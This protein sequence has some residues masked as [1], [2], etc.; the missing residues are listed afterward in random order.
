MLKVESGAT[1]TIIDGSTAQTGTIRGGWTQNGGNINNAGTLN[2]HGG[3]ITGGGDVNAKGGGIWNQGTLNI[4]GNVRVNGN[5]GSDIFLPFDK[6]VNVTGAI[7]SGVNSIGI[8][9]EQTGVF[10]AGYGGA[11]AIGGGTNFLGAEVNITGGIVVAFSS[12]ED[13]AI[14]NGGYCKTLDNGK[15]TIPA[16]YQ[17]KAG[18]NAENATFIA[19][20]GRVAACQA[21]GLYQY[22]RIEPCQ[23]VGSNVRIT[24]GSSHT[25]Y[26]CGHCLKGEKNE[27]HTFGDY[28]ECPVC[29]LICLSDNGSNANT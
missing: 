20:D 5:E 26:E 24:D 23:H 18:D 19:S 28:G 11:A 29:H 16:T 25:L 9:M 17:V 7:T 27:P 10:T 14:G 21:E 6:T 3:L 15:L 2:L 13:P 4:E 22:V 12:K 1:L 8:S